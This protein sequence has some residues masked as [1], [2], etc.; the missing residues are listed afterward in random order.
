[1]NLGTEFKKLYKDPSKVQSNMRDIFEIATSN[2]LEEGKGWYENANL[3][4]SSLAEKHNLDIYHTAGVI[5]AFSPST[6]WEDNMIRA[7]KFI[8]TGKLQGHLSQQIKKAIQILVSE[9]HSEVASILN[10]PKTVNFFYNIYNPN[11][12]E[13]VTIDRHM[14]NL[15]SRIEGLINPTP[16]QYSFLF[17]ETVKFAKSVNLMPNQVQAILWI[18][19]RKHKNIYE[20]QQKSNPPEEE[21]FEF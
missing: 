2:D 6:A 21:S 17:K 9:C 11:L 3:F 18:T 12:E 5:S 16:K 10:G 13:Y 15:A 1:M 8:N 14:V 19:W 7:E 20:N 4:A